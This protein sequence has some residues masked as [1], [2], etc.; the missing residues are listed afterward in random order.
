MNATAL[1]DLYKARGMTLA[2]AESC[3]GGLVAAALTAVPGSSAVFTNGLVTYANE[4]KAKLLGVPQA[5]LAEHGAVSAQVAKAMAEGARRC[6]GTD[7]AISVTGIAGPGGG[8][9][10]KP[11]GTVWFGL[12][13]AKGSF[14]EHQLFTGT[15]D[16]IRA[17]AVAYALGLASRAA[18]PEGQS[19]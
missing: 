13:T 9:P 14:A 4:A 5:T 19:T 2:T 18:N 12:A 10:E 3:T 16:E 17:K 8:S 7:A 15:R 1:I 11:I 6:T